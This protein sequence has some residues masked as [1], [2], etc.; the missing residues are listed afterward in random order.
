MAD[1]AA[2]EDCSLFNFG[3]PDGFEFFCIRD[4]LDGGDVGVG[5][6]CDATQTALRGAPCDSDDDCGADM[7][8]QDADGNPQR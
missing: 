5:E 2:G 7:G 3:S 8:C 1:C 4:E 6:S